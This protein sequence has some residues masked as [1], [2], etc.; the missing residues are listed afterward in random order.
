MGENYHLLRIRSKLA[1]DNKYILMAKLPFNAS[2]TVINGHK[3]S[4]ISHK[5]HGHRP[6]TKPGAEQDHNGTEPSYR[7]ARILENRPSKF[8]QPHRT[9]FVAGTI[10][11]ALIWKWRGD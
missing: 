8:S 2:L 10:T 4:D 7:E 9:S 1:H 5:P 3:G 6:Q 11:Q